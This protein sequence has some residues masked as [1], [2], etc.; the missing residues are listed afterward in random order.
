MRFA[1]LAAA[2]LL[3]ACQTQGQKVDNRPV[4]VDGVTFAPEAP[5]FTRAEFYASLSDSAPCVARVA[6][7]NPGIS[8]TARHT[9]CDCVR[10]EMADTFDMDLIQRLLEEARGVRKP[11]DR[12]TLDDMGSRVIIQ[13]AAAYRRCGLRYND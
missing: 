3:A 12:A 6:K 7:Y 5:G 11:L 13:G 1:A 2:L 10:R 8:T 9:G 4:T